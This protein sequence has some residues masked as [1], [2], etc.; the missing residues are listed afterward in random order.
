MNQ[1]EPLVRPAIRMLKPYRSARQDALTGTLLDANENSFGSVVA[2]DGIP[3]HR[4]PDPLQRELRSALGELNGVSPD[5]V[6]AG[7]GS[8]ELIDLLLRIFCEPGRDEILILEP[9][10]GMYRVCAEIQGVTVRSCP[11]DDTF[12]I[13]PEEVARHR[14]DRTKILFCCSP[15]NPTGNLLR[16]GDIL[17]L[18]RS[19]PGLVVVDEAYIDFSPEGTCAGLLPAAPN[20]VILRTLSKAWGLA[21]IRLGYCLA[22]PLVVAYLLKIKPP[23]NINALTA[24]Y[25]L[26]GL[27]H[28]EQMRGTVA[29]IVRERNRLVNGLTSLPFVE[30][31]YPS[32][33][34]FIL[35]RFSSA[36]SIYER[37]A[38]RGIIVRDRSAEPRLDRCL[39]I[40]V[41]T[42]EQ[43]TL[44]L[45]E[46]ASLDR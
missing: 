12:H 19:T 14:G 42:P 46:L 33:A 15:N 31:I 10:Y 32:D 16:V 43:N 1:I 27:L 34:N 6:A 36:R 18:C 25:A 35:V 7:V 9:T 40:T 38:Q 30:R 11:L 13:D 8:D 37:L 24:A 17:S 26:Q 3:L 5:S 39:R 20:L 4:Y 29:R 2:A 41:G 23:Y 21:G 28:R 45:H 22:H 44:L